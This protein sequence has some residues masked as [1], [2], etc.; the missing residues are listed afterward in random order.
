MTVVRLAVGGAATAQAR[1]LAAP[2]VR[3]A[4]SGS[5]GRSYKSFPS[6]TQGKAPALLVSYAYRA[7]WEKLLLHEPYYR[8]WALDSGAF[9]AK[10][11]GTE[12]NLSDYIVFVRERQARD[13]TLAEVFALD[14]IGDSRATL[15]NTAAMWK[16]GVEAI[17]TYHVGEPEWVLRE[18]AAQYPKIALGGM[19]GMASAPKLRF[20]NACLSRVWPK[21]V[22]GF[23]VANER[24]LM[25]APLHSAD[26]TSW[27]GGPTRFGR[28]SH[29][30]MSVRGSNQ[31][32][33]GEVAF[34]VDLEARLGVRWRKE[35]K[36][37]E[38]L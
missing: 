15:D 16:A 33:T 26:A 19:V 21:K 37:L 29:G 12:V 35:M 17:P 14:V 38:A 1:A 13:V 6:P 31:D 18:I 32:L 27:E 20:I 36:E 23:G 28:W 4:V 30:W 3:L 34:Y 5:G 25:A 8:D 24:I 7:L 10:Q 11:S 22:H 9:T 2:V